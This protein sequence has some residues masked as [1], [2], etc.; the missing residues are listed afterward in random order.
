MGFERINEK[1]RIERI[2]QERP[3]FRFEYTNNFYGSCTFTARLV[4]RKNQPLRLDAKSV[5]VETHEI[6]KGGLT[7]L[8]S[9]ARVF[10]RTVLVHYSSLDQLQDDPV[11]QQ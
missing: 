7:R 2:A 4:E 3:L 9:A 6:K 8:L 11:F 10:F 1:G 5:S